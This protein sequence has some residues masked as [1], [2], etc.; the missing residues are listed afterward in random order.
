MSPQLA[1]TFLTTAPQQ[2]QQCCIVVPAQSFDQDVLGDIA[3]GW[4]HFVQTGQVWAMLIGLVVG[5][6]LRSVTA[7]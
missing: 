6:M 5:Y 4:N 2:A 7:S 3:R 1:Y